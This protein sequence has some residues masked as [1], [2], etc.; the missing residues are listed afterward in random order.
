MDEVVYHPGH[1]PESVM[2]AKERAGGGSA[3][4]R[5]DLP[6]GFFMEEPSG[7]GPTAAF[8]SLLSRVPGGGAALGDAEV[9][10]EMSGSKA[11][12]THSFSNASVRRVALALAAGVDAS[13]KLPGALELICVD[14]TPRL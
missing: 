7:A 12:C 4:F 13:E 9:P 10:E 14:A 11:F 8:S 5:R 6:W 2:R 1:Q 3:E